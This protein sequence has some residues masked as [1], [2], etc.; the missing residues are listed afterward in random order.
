MDRTQQ[1][2]EVSAGV[3]QRTSE[4]IAEDLLLYTVVILFTEDAV[5][6]IKVPNLH[7]YWGEYLELLRGL[8]REYFPIFTQDTSSGTYRA[9]DDSIVRLKDSGMIRLV[10]GLHYDTIHF[11]FTG[12]VATKIQIGADPAEWDAV[13]KATDLIER[14]F[15]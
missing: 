14:K 8:G 11:G 3:K 15:K 6:S 5:R 10:P 7:K 2:E 4:Q 1:T 13:E 12:S 9:I